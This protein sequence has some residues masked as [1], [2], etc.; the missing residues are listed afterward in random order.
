S[1]FA[2]AR[3]KAQDLN[4]ETKGV[5]LA[6]LITHIQEKEGHTACFRAKETCLELGCCWQLSCG[7]S[8]IKE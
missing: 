2:V 4:I 6:E 5:K 1:L 3:D 7:A 8:M